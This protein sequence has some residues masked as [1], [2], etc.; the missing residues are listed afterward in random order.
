MFKKGKKIIL[1]IF[2]LVVFCYWQNNSLTVSHYDIKNEKI[3]REFKNFK[4]VQISDL[5]NKSFGN[6]QKRLVEKINN[7]KPDIILI[8]GDVVDS[9]RTNFVPA[10]AL[11]KQ[12][13]QDYPIYYVP[14]NHE[15]RLSNYNEL[16]KQLTD[17]GVQILDNKSIMVNRGNAQISLTGLIDP[18]F[19]Y[20]KSTDDIEIISKLLKNNC[21]TNQNYEILLAH[22]PELIGEYKKGNVD[23]T[24]SGHAHG[25]Q[26]RLPVIGALV[27]P[28]Q[29]FFP[30]YTQ[31][32]HQE[33]SSTLVVSR[34]LGNSL[35][36]FRLFDR[37][38]VVSVSLR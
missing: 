13:S 10:V 12:L 21:N 38:D 15:S 37:P 32:I 1:G 9:R 27:A 8:T 36:P 20:D 5:H 6:E 28:N 18:S 25:G 11:G 17:V 30:K 33:G 4:I 22:R 34:G 24:F 31:G 3:P 19:Y 16:A 7:E 14:G 2:I 26:V 23:L 29:G 35:F